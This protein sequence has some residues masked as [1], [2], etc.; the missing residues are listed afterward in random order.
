MMKWLNDLPKLDAS[1]FTWEL[2]SPDN[3]WLV[4]GGHI[5]PDGWIPLGY[6]DAAQLA[7]RP[8]PGVAVLFIDQYGQEFWMHVLSEC[9]QTT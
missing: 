6:C 8:R 5:L 9:L 4:D 7:V 1:T 2:Y 3:S